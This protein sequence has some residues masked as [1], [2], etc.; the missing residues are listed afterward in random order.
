MFK[1]SPSYLSLY[2]VLMCYVQQAHGDINVSEMR[3]GLLKNDTH[4]LCIHHRHEKGINLNGEL[5]FPSLMGGIWD[6]LYT[7]KLHLGISI[8]TSGYTSHVYTGLTWFLHMGKFVIEPTFGFDLNNGERG[9]R[10][11][12]RQCMGSFIAFRESISLGY[13]FDD[14]WTG[15]VMLDHVSHAG[16][17]HPNPGISTVG[18]RL[19]YRF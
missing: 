13:Q 11:Q 16:I 8:N 3:V 4:G 7:P 10:N 19:G 5:L 2:A 1:K 14:K 18:V 15:Y 12:K 6:Y 17:F 9:K